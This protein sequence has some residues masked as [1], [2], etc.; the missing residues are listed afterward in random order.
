[1]L[2]IK[3]L[4]I[5]VITVS[6]T[7]F[8]KNQHWISVPKHI[9]VGDQRLLHCLVS[10]QDHHFFRTQ[11]NSENWPIFPVELVKENKIGLRKN[12]LVDKSIRS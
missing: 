2:R 3:N 11:M 8:L 9:V 7:E 6:F 4:L 5:S 10:C 1:M 12:N